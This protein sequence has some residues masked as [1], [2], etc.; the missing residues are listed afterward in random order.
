VANTLKY[1]LDWNS[2]K[3]NAT[4]VQTCAE[5]LFYPHQQKKGFFMPHVETLPFSTFH[6]DDEGWYQAPSEGIKKSVG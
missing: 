3:T 6:L 2:L 4:F 1:S 5:A